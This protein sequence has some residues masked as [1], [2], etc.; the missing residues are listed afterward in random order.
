MARKKQGKRPPYPPW[1]DL[2]G[3]K[4]IERWAP[5]WMPID[6][7]KE[8]RRRMEVLK[9]H[10]GVKTWADL[11]FAIASQLD[12]ALHPT[13]ES[14]RQTRRRPS[15]GITAA[16][17]A[18]P[19]GLQL[20]HVVDD[21]RDELETGSGKKIS[22]YRLAPILADPQQFPGIKAHWA[23]EFGQVI[24]YDMHPDLLK[25]RY[26]VSFHHRWQGMVSMPGSSKR[27]KMDQK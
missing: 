18:G 26:Q 9:K 5:D 27:K 12:I 1:G 20:L 6:I 22:W 21:I 4:P 10:Y 2:L 23:G 14:Y 16:K 11:A 7:G 24:D 3:G 17:W 13:P 19:A 15:K 25:A 8:Q